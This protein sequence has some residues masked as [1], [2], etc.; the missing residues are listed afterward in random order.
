MTGIKFT[1]GWLGVNAWSK[2]LGGDGL[3]LPV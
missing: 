3:R 2:A 1:T